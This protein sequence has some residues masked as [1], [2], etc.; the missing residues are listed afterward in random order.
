MHRLLL[1]ALLLSLPLTALAP[2]ASAGTTHEITL[3]VAPEGMV[4]PGHW[5]VGNPAVWVVDPLTVTAAN[6]QSGIAGCV[7]DVPT[8]GDGV[9]DGIDVL[10]HAEATGCIASWDGRDTDNGVFVTEV[11]GRE[12]IGFPGPWWMIQ[13]NGFSSPVGVS[14]MDLRDGASLS[15]VY[16]TGV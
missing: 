16:Y 4:V 8:G 6:G 2:S 9:V 10:D 1:A 3:R 14:D 13:L 12:E 5:T 11:D 7:L 15:F